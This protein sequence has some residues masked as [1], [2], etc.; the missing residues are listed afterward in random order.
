MADIFIKLKVYGLAWFLLF[1][2]VMSTITYKIYKT[3]CII[4]V[5]WNP[6]VFAGFNPLYREIITN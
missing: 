2:T 5:G 6:G 4:T 3:N 1:I